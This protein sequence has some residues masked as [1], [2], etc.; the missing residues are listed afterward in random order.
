ME[1][2]KQLEKKDNN[3]KEL[4][5]LWGWLILVCIGLL[6]TPIQL[7]KHIDDNYIPVIND[8][9]FAQLI[10]K[11]SSFY[12]EWF[13][14]LSIFEFIWT[15]IFILFPI[16]LIYLF[17]SK[18]I[19][20]PFYYK[21]FLISNLIFLLLD[22]V[23]GNLIPEIAIIPDGWEIKE[24]I[25][26]FLTVLIWWSYIHVSKRVKNTF[27]EEKR[28]SNALS[29]SLTY[30]VVIFIMIFSVFSALDISKFSFTEK[31]YW[32]KTCIE[33]FWEKSIYT[34]EKEN[35]EFL[36]DCIEWYEFWWTNFNKCVS[37]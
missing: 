36:C 3:K 17:F 1:K 26:T 20:F 12:I 31:E 34:W 37:E 2:I 22:F 4:K 8:W 6:I 18:N 9:S 16:F 5:W 29:I 28:D 7:L 14:P 10:N 13:L 21:I 15:F 23:L 30:L 32:N 19:K 27:I 11:T 25:S 33:N 24:L 35:G